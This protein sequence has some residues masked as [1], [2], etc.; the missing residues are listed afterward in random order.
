MK[1]EVRI[2]KLEFILI[3]IKK[4]CVKRMKE[5]TNL[6]IITNEEGPLWTR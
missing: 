4:M 5:K 6:I 1:Y 3:K 2:Y